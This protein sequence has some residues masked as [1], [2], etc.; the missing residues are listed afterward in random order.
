MDAGEARRF[1]AANR[2]SLR[3]HILASGAV[4]IGRAERTPDGLLEA[5]F[6]GQEGPDP[7]LIE[8]LTYPDRRN[9]DEVLRDVAQVFLARGIVPDVFTVVLRPRGSFR[10]S[11]EW[12]LPSRHNWTLFEGRWRV[13]ELWTIP[14]AT[15]LAT[16]DVGLVPWA[17]LADFTEPPEVLLPVPRQDRQARKTG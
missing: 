17:I 5:F 12:H 11:G 9:A 4:G 7:F 2:W 16:N 15:L 3:I 14:A 10:L 1:A 8:I 13:V 6:P